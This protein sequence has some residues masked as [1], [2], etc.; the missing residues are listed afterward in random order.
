MNRKKLGGGYGEF[1][2]AG[3]AADGSEPEHRVV[4]LP[5]RLEHL[6]PYTILFMAACPIRFRLLSRHGV[7][8]RSSLSFPRTFLHSC[9]YKCMMILFLDRF[10]C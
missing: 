4:H 8:R 3:G 2:R 7:D 6:H 5:R 1:V 10:I 9:M